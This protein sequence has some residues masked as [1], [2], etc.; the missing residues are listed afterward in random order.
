M[1]N[2][3]YDQ[4]LIYSICHQSGSSWTG[5]YTGWHHSPSENCHYQCGTVATSAV[6]TGWACCIQT[7]KR[8]LSLSKLRTHSW[9][10]TFQQCSGLCQLLAAYKCGVQKRTTFIVLFHY[11][12]FSMEYFP[13]N[14][15]FLL[16]FPSS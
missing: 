15:S 13:G 10:L 6:E 9:P 3:I 2:R 7:N 4:L 11:S 14:F 16:K 5:R 8:P 1:K 12:G